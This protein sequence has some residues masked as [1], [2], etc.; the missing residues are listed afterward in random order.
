MNE[1]PPN[2]PDTKSRT[3]II[4]WT[5]IGTV[6]AFALG[7]EA[8]FLSRGCQ[9]TTL[10]E[11]RKSAKSNAVS[12]VEE[13]APIIEPVDQIGDPLP[14]R[15]RKPSARVPNDHF[16]NRFTLDTPAH[17]TG[18]N[19]GAS[20]E[21]GERIQNTQIG[22]VRWG[23]TLWWQW[24]APTSGPVII[25]TIGSDYDT[26]LAVY[27]GTAV[28]ALTVV[29][30]NDNE[31][32]V[33][34]GASRVAFDAK[35]G[36]EYEI[37]V[38]GV[39][40]G[41]GRGSIPTTGTLQL[42][43][44][45]PPSITIDSPIGGGI[46]PV[47]SNIAVNAT[48][49]SITGSITN[50]N[51]Y[52]GPQLLGSATAIPCNINVKNAPAGTNSLYAVAMDSIGQIRTSAVVS[53][54]VASVGITIASPSADA[55]F[56]NANPITVSAFPMLPTG[57]IT[58]VSFFVDGQLIG[59][60]AGAPFSVVWSSVASGSHRL[61]ARGLDNSGNTYDATPVSIAVART[62]FPTG[63]VWKYLDNGSDQGTAWFAPDFNDRSWKSGPAEL[64]YGDKDEATRVEDNDTPG[65][66][67]RDT[68]HYITTY[69]RRAFVVTSIA[70]YTHLLMSV[71]RDDGAVVYLNGREAARFNMNAGAVN[72]STLA[73]NAGDDGKV[74]IP[75]TLPANLLTEGTNVV[76]VEIHQATADSTDISFDMDLLGVPRVE[77]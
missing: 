50:V 31:S 42:N 49:M 77:H 16:V 21:R 56:N 30:E 66:N 1:G 68:E 61:T 17:V 37:Q 24:I 11:T 18:A 12:S 9:R 75:V 34:V 76:A 57:S 45:M 5:S 71:K 44:A 23:D 32:E 63:S 36:T 38:G 13:I 27:T 55:V 19:A 64:G 29:A 48:A 25:D 8:F 43:L 58:N 39:F 52:R 65:F 40:T 20:N 35:V 51:F 6:L 62:F 7:I 33:G 69:F 67:S 10:V 60:K 4:V 15:P 28:N 14:P 26:Y 73:R 41:G 47:G 3:W 59:Q 70:S 46:F 72:Y 22:L 54:L 53:V 74:F 2:P